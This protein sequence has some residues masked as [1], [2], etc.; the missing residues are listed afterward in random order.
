MKVILVD[1]EVY[2][3]DVLE[4]LLKKHCP[5]LQIVGVFNQSLVALEALR[6]DP[7]D[8]L[9]LDIEMPQMNG[10]E[11]LQQLGNYNF[12]V[13]FTTAYDQYAISAFKF[14]TIDYLLKPIDKNEL[15]DAVQKCNRLNYHLTEKIEHAYYLKS[16]PVPERI[17]LPIDKNLYFVEVAQIIHCEADGSYCRIFLQNETKPYLLSKSLKEIEELLNNPKFFRT[18]ASYLI[19][20]DHIFKIS[21]TDGMDITM[22][23]NA[24]IPVSRTKKGDLMQRI[25]KL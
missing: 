25:A 8:L 16:N 19:N 11:L 20:T 4:I 6:S 9:F 24:L 3:T 21:K 2:C 10:F 7:P 22:R 1:D 23:N 15:L 17:A 12:N 18:H 14:N 13:I 5:D